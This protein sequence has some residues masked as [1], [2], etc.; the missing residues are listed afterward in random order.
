MKR[1]LLPFAVLAALALVATAGIFLTRGDDAPELPPETPKTGKLSSKAV[2][3]EEK[4]R[5]LQDVWRNNEIAFRDKKEFRALADLHRDFPALAAEA[6]AIQGDTKTE[7][8]ALPHL[9]ASLDASGRIAG[10]FVMYHV[11]ESMAT[12]ES[13][14]KAKEDA[15]LAN[16]EWK[17]WK[18]GTQ[19]LSREAAPAKA[20]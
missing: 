16:A 17:A 18:D 1:A 2:A 5:T 13:W 20:P 14:A 6:R 4:A 15:A 10:V 7:S 19:T 11:N 12:A 9:I 3:I 8:D